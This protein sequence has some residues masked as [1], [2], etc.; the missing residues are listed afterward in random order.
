MR[1]RRSV[2]RGIEARRGNPACCEVLP[3]VTLA[4]YLTSSIPKSDRVAVEAHLY[5]C[6]ECWAVLD[7]AYKL[8]AAQ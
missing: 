3:S 4:R 2:D 7:N 6:Q 5:D 1:E 8:L